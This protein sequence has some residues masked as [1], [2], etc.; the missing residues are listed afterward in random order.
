M[1]V[2]PEKEGVSHN[3]IDTPKHLHEYPLILH[4][5]LCH[6]NFCLL[7]GN[8]PLAHSCWLGTNHPTNQHILGPS[9]LVA[10]YWS[11]RF[12]QR[13]YGPAH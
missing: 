10:T 3:W 9:P 2:G 7:R 5:A 13:E 8:T 12:L 6:A 1:P 4:A 11:R